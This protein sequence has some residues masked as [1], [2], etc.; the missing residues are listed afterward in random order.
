VNPA[1][2]SRRTA[3]AAAQGV[4]GE[5]PGVGL[6]ASGVE[7]PYG[8]AA[9]ARPAAQRWG[10]APPIDVP[11]PGMPSLG[12]S[13]TRALQMMAAGQQMEAARA[14]ADTV[15]L[16]WPKE[17]PDVDGATMAD[18]LFAHFLVVFQSLEEP[19]HAAVIQWMSLRLLTA[20][21]ASV[22]SYL[23]RIRSR[24]QLR[25]GVDVSAHP[26]VR[27]FVKRLMALRG[28]HRQNFRPTML[29][30]EYRAVLQS[31]ALPVAVKAL[32]VLA[33]RRMARVADILELRV[34]GLWQAVAAEAGTLPHG[35]VPVWVEQPFTK[36]AQAGAFDRVLVAL[37]PLEERIVCA[38]LAG[39]GGWDPQPP[40]LPPHRR[41]LLFP[42]LTTPIVAQYLNDAV[43]RRVGAHAL[44]RSAMRAAIQ[45]GIPLPQAMLLSL[46]NT[47][48]AAT[49]YVIRPDGDTSARMFQAS[50]A[51]GGVAASPLPGR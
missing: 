6:R 30:A 51:T 8:C 4:G 23:I 18:R 24:L 33:W 27:L 46:H 19:P 35:H 29:A 5:P 7:V 21:A 13:R 25:F 9:V 2:E 12:A 39:C 22:V 26:L 28:A 37:D 41:P 48:E 1:P 49:A 3:E 11:R 32:V 38:H 44:R 43:G 50:L 47:M 14:I 31:D 34:G 42:S 45:A 17:R 16:P 36:V 40:A 20:D 15:L 10:R